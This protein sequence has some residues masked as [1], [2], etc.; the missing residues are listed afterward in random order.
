MVDAILKSFVEHF[1]LHVGL[2]VGV[3][4]FINQIIVNTVV[5]LIIG[6]TI[7]EGTQALWRRWRNKSSHLFP[8]FSRKSHALQGMRP[9]EVRETSLPLREAS[10]RR[11]CEMGEFE[12]VFRGWLAERPPLRRGSMQIL[13]KKLKRKNKMTHIGTFV[14][15]VG[16]LAFQL[17]EP[18][19]GPLSA[20]N[21]FLTQNVGLIIGIGCLASLFSMIL[22]A[23][24]RHDQSKLIS[25]VNHIEN[26][27]NRKFDEYVQNLL[28]GYMNIKELMEKLEKA[29]GE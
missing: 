13:A 17:P 26:I 2:E 22:I 8:H 5:S 6:I 23:K 27:V 4:S 9:R 16:V 14:T 12:Y 25:T 21:N 18:F 20:I 28:D 15:N 10:V 24:I 7:V 3:V 19:A 11:V 29:R 1:L